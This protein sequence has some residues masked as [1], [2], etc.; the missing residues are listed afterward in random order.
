MAEYRI[1]TWLGGEVS[2]YSC[3]LPD[4]DAARNLALKYVGEIMRDADGRIFDDGLRVEVACPDR[5][6][7]R[8]EAT[9]THD[10]A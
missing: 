9:A 6:V 4:P 8:V 7:I 10:R 5:T 2:T 3:D 1:T